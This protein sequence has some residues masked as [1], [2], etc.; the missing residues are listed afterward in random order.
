MILNFD[1]TPCKYVPVPTTTLLERNPKQVAIKGIDDKRAIT[2]TFTITLDGNFLGMQLI[3]GG[4]TNQSLPRYQFPKEFSLSVN[5]KHYNNENE[6]MKL[7]D[8]I[9]LP[10]LMRER[11][12]L[13]RRTQKALVIFDVF[14]GQITDKVLD[15]FKENNIATVF[16]PANMTGQLQPL[17]LTV[18]GYAK[19]YC[20]KKFN[21]WYMEQIT[22]KL[23]SGKPIDEIEVKLQLTKLKPLHAE[24]LTDF[25]N[26]MTTS[27]GKDVIL[28][29]WKAAGII[30]VIETGSSQLGSL[31]PFKDL[32]PLLSPALYNETINPTM[33]SDEVRHAFI[34][35]SEIQ[36][37]ADGSDSEDDDVYVPDDNQSIFNIFKDIGSES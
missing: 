20:K 9:I 35:P 30:Q 26:L 10:Y 29:G 22:K 4:K 15:Y 37:E 19:K 27:E 11:E 24:W 21:E 6:S 12:R 31:D 18:N 16:V 2:A 32:D 34:D 7:I 36:H 3:Y 17:D 28:S 1:Q 5:L 8:E 23:D 25:Y 33:L 13:N 14:R